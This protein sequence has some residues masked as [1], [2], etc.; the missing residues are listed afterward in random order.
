MALRIF[1]Y[2]R[3][4]IVIDGED[5]AIRVKRLTPQESLNFKREF[6]RVSQ[7]AAT[8]PEAETREQQA[9]REQQEYDLAV[10]AQGFVTKS[11]SDY[12]TVEPGHLI[13]DDSQE[14]FTD[15]GTLVRL[16]GSRDDVLQELL[17]I[18][19]FENRLNADQ[20]THWKSRLAPFVPTPIDVAARMMTLAQVTAQDRIIDPGCGSG[21]LCIAAATLGARA[22]GYD[23][24]AER[25][26][27][28]TEAAKAV[29]VEGLCT[30][31]V[32]DA[33]TVDFREAT[34]V[35]VYLLTSGM[36]KMRPILQAQLPVGARVVS[37]A[38]TMGADWPA[39]RTEH[40]APPEGEKYDHFGAR[41][42]YL[43][44]IDRWR[45]AHPTAP[46]L[47]AVGA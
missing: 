39:D 2:F 3:S 31:Q 17:L 26:R 20:K 30:F 23:I 47:T 6:Q 36:A 5:I 32:R 41:W 45:A 44:A 13:E 40:I 15:G 22:I 4:T 24:D 19:N 16:F 9:A 7:P 14:S 25:I 10:S 35:P 8:A 21:R 42:V 28:A 29:G 33:L 1:S 46:A 18:I 34:V 27:E 11:I 38:F 43:Y 12:V 37:H